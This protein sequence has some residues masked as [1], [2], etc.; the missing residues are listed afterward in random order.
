M[1]TF[2]SETLKTTCNYQDNV[3][4]EIN[5]TITPTLVVKTRKGL[6][7]IS[8]E[9]ILYVKCENFYCVLI[10]EDGRQLDYSCSLMQIEEKLQ[11]LKFSK[12]SRNCLV[13]LD[14]VSMVRRY[15]SRK[16]SVLMVNQTE[17]PIAYRRLVE[18]KKAYLNEL[19][20]GEDDALT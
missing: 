9:K 12:I 3:M 14:Y 16:W 10:M 2:S 7:K 11:H 6:T 19:M 8:M 1:K 15:N 20:E 4:E 13:N 17:I 5:N 18:F